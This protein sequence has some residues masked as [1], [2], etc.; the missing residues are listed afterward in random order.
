MDKVTISNDEQM[1]LVTKSF[2]YLCLLLF[3]VY[4]LTAALCLF[5]G[6]TSPSKG[7]VHGGMGK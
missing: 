5:P 3:S 4:V 6:T 1:V 2:L 7:L